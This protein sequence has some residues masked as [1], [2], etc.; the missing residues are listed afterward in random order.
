M[1]LYLAPWLAAVKSRQF[2]TQWSLKIKVRSMIL[3]WVSL[4]GTATVHM[5]TLVK[6]M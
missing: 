4:I 5:E 6:F 2:R 3:M 1:F